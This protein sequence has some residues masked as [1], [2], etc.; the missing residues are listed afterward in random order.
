MS[1]GDE[2]ADS[3]HKLGERLR[4]PGDF[5]RPNPQPKLAE[6]MHEVFIGIGHHLNNV[7]AALETIHGQ[8]LAIEQQ[9]RRRSPGG[10][11]RYLLAMFIGVAALLAWQSYSEAA[12]QIIATNAPELGW[13]PGARQMIAGWV[14]QLRW[15]KTPAVAEN[16]AQPF[17]PGTQQLASAVQTAPENV[18]SKPVAPSI[19]PE[20]VHQIASD[21][22]AQRQ[23][24]ELIAAGQ[25]QMAHEV[26][27]LQGAVA[28][29]L[30]KIP[31]PPPPPPVAAAVPTRP[32][33]AAVPTRPVAV[34]A[35][36]PPVAAAV[37][38]RPIAAA[39]PTRPVAVAAPAP[40]V[41]AAVPAPKPKPKPMAP[42]WSRGPMPRYG[43]PYG[44]PY[45]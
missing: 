20:Q 3:A 43:S 31:E 19:D 13:S 45:Q 34:A 35:P 7:T 9:T 28:E 44:P 16:T 26:D 41:A 38:A 32:I 24:I 33:A 10:F 8:L 39:V 14:Q 5:Q 40:P 25:D 6:G 15:S 11:A 42:P 36:A 1:P 18:T 30:V 2:M 29:I 37:P 27:R 22:V 21:V 12:K 17:V 23:T 4:S